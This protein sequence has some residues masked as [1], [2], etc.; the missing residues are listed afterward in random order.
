MKRNDLIKHL[1][2][3]GCFLKREGSSHS[4]WCNPLTGHCETVP[5]HT[6][7]PDK[8]AR[9]ICKTSSIKEIG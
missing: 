1:R 4:L 6:E 3:N 2:R 8:L 7:I 5:R 9:K